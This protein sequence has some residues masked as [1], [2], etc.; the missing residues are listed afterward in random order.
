MAD[1][2]LLSEADKREIR[3]AIKLVTDQFFVT[4]VH[5]HRYLD[6]VDRFNEDRPDRFSRPYVLSALVEYPSGG[7]DWAKELQ[8]GSIDAAHIKVT[9]NYEDLLVLNLLPAFSDDYNEDY[10]TVAGVSSLVN[11]TEKIHK[12][13]SG[14]DCFFTQGQWYK[15]VYAGY[16]GPLDRQNVLI[17]VYGELRKTG[18][19]KMIPSDG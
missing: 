19:P 2:P 17:V 11:D 12:M 15:V 4:P 3:D 5:Y 6:S 13:T 14:S 7:S 16:D 18:N 10:D 9:L 8:Q 1:G